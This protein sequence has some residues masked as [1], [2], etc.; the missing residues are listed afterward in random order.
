MEQQNVDQALTNLLEIA[1][2]ILGEA[3]LSPLLWAGIAFYVAYRLTRWR[4]GPKFARTPE[5]P[6]AAGEAVIIDGVACDATP[7]MNR[8][9]HALA[10]KIEDWAHKRRLDL[11]MSPEVSYGAFVKTRD[12][13]A[14][15]T[16]AFKRADLVL[17]D[18]RDARVRLVI[19]F[20]GRGHWGRSGDERSRARR[21]DAVKNT[22]ATTAGIP[23]LRVRTNHSVEELEELLDRA[24]GVRAPAE[25]SA[26]QPRPGGTTEGTAL[27]DQSS[28]GYSRRRRSRPSL[29]A[30][31]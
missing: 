4:L 25:A 8:G 31:R 28:D 23:L 15:R 18:P 30:T 16:V 24:L 11:R 1:L 3:L 19:E 26:P 14:W 5:G 21:S 2:G 7:L 27:C 17:W 20:D 6:P 22:A 29:R 9:E 13:N 10:C 12:P